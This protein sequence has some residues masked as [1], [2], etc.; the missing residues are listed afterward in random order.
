MLSFHG[1]FVQ[2]RHTDN[3]KTICPRSFDTG[4]KK[5]DDIYPTVVYTLKKN[6]YCEADCRVLNEGKLVGCPD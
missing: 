5:A 2:T 4:H 6:S 3:G 1:T